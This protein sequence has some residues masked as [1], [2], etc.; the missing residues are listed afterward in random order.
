[1]T[2]VLNFIRAYQLVN[3]LIWGQTGRQ[4]G[5]LLSLFFFLGRKVS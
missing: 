1:M 4:E 3:K 2:S 5:D